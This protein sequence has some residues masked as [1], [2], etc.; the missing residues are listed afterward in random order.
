MN[1]SNTRILELD[2][3]KSYSSKDSLW[4]KHK[5]YSDT[6][7]NFYK[8]THHHR[9]SERITDCARYLSFKL[10]P[11]PTGEMSLKLNSV[12]L[13]H[14]RHC[15]VCAWC[16][17]RVW[18]MRF[19]EAMPRM[20][21][22]HSGLRFLFL[23]LTVR[24]VP[25]EELRDSI[26]HISKAFSKLMKRR[27]I[28]K[29]ILGYA[30]ALEVTRSKI[31]EAHPHLHILIAV[32]PGYFSGKNYI[33]F[34]EWREMWKES[35][36]VDYE[37]FINVQ[38]IKP[39]EDKKHD[40]DG[41]ISSVCEVAKYTVKPSDLLGLG[42]ENRSSFDE[43]K[44]WLLELT[45]QM[46]GVKQMNLSGIFRQYLREEEPEEEEILK[47]FEEEEEETDCKSE[48]SRLFFQWY[49]QIK[50]YARSLSD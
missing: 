42:E 50:H 31:N 32:K 20:V 37:P 43:N 4:D 13:C 6:L 24:N 14:I 47:S 7:V 18:R 23:T 1:K 29:N 21:S 28:D 33:K 12:Y 2:L 10:T 11:S 30:R 46:H 48:E 49:K 26:S 38:T 3:L 8:D 45:D 44:N 5:S 36:G 35:L 27:K 34:E 15:T 25:I 16:K 19:F 39:H 9:Y 22:D 40:K 41:I 17:Q